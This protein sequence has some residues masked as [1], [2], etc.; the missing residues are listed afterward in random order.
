[1]CQK[2]IWNVNLL[3]PFLLIIYLF[4]KTSHRQVYLHNCAD[5]LDDNP[6]ETDKV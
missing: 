4:M 5:Y 3:Q 2:M 6:F 1:M